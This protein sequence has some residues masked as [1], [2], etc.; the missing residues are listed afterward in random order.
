VVLTD[1][2]MEG[3]DGISLCRALKESRPEL[4][5]IVIT[6][7]ARQQTAVEALRAG[8][9]DFL[10]KP[11]QPGLLLPCVSRALE[12]QQLARELRAH[13]R[14]G[15]GQLFG[16][17]E[18]IRRVMDVVVRVAPS[19]ASVLIQGETGSG[20]ELVARELHRLSP[21]A[22]APFIAINCAALP[23]SL[24]ESE[25]FGYAKGA[26]TDARAARTGLFVESSGGTLF[27]DEVAEL[28]LDNQAKLLRA[29]QERKVRPLGSSAEVPFDARVL[30]AT[31]RELETEVAA[32]RFR[33]DLFFR[34]NVIRV[35]LPPLRQ[36]G[37]DILHL[38]TRF[39]ARVCERDGRPPLRLTP[40]V[41]NRL[42]AHAW[43][44]NV[45]ELENC[46]ERLVALCDGSALSA[47]D[48]PQWIQESSGPAADALPK[49]QEELVTLE[50]LE[51]RY[52]QRVLELCQ[53]NRS[54]AAEVLG[55]DR[56]TL[57][58]RL[59]TAKANAAHRLPSSA[60]TPLR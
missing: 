38:A 28:T 56:R 45:R 13:G 34:L 9:Y 59:D 60:G 14:A 21:R 2:G 55:I 26:F 6:G 3:L 30:C 54:K 25:L 1:V 50:E 4:P 32:G 44:G 10:T 11:I 23:A 29:L 15:E 20:K 42:L 8:A 52:I 43:P 36:R 35:D 22:A 31:H 16:E 48:L 12:R 57:Y 33:Q 27:L 49:T 46:I 18:A 24:V 58:R 37:M 41:A 51:R 19:G 40:E 17:S 5:I 53:H 7:E 47:G 39:L